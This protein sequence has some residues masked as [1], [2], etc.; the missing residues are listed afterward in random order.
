MLVNALAMHN[1]L[2]SPLITRWS[3]LN[4]PSRRLATTLDHDAGNEALG[5][6]GPGPPRFRPS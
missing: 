4:F 3:V 2:R 1:V 5:T 6:D